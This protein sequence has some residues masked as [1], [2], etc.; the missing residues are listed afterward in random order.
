MDFDKAVA[1]FQRKK[2]SQDLATVK[3]EQYR[4]MLKEYT[5]MKYSP[6]VNGVRRERE[7]TQEV[8]EKR[9]EEKKAVEIDTVADGLIGFVDIDIDFTPTPKGRKRK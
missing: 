6:A 4:T 2:R 5:S 8:I 9:A 1:A 7:I 3:R